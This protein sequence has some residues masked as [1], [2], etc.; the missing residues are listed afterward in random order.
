[1][2]DTI[3]SVVTYL[4]GWTYFRPKWSEE[5][6]NKETMVKKLH[7]DELRTCV[8]KLEELMWIFHRDLRALDAAL[9]FHVGHGGTDRHPL[10]T[11]TLAGFMSPEDK[12][13]A[14][15]TH[16]E[17]YA[18]HD[19]VNALRRDAQA[20]IDEK[21]TYYTRDFYQDFNIESFENGGGYPVY[22]AN[23]DISSLEAEVGKGLKVFLVTRVYAY[24]SGNNDYFNGM[25]PLVGTTVKLP[26]DVQ[27]AGDNNIVSVKGIF[28]QPNIISHNY[29]MA[30][31]VRL[32]ARIT[33]A[34]KGAVGTG[35]SAML[36]RNNWI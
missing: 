34:I 28:N 27:E 10:V 14:D 36:T 11:H 20:Y 12:I 29:H 15:N 6:I 8:M 16:P 3:A 31:S 13:K 5:L 30:G 21:T 2:A 7:I 25:M 24:G 22:T 23:F 4:H 1:M 33:C 26:P 18:T 17:T 9:V 32:A 35:G 19:E